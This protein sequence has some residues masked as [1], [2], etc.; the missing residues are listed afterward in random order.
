MSIEGSLHPTVGI[1]WL[2][3]LGIESRLLGLVPVVVSI[4]GYLLV[5][6]VL[7]KFARRSS[8]RFKVNLHDKCGKRPQ[9]RAL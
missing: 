2:H 7:R 5:L 8:R 6:N 9:S 1:C 4:M 3:V